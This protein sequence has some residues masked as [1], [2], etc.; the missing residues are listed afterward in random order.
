MP[1]ADVLPDLDEHRTYL[2][3]RHRLA[4]YTTALNEVVRP[5]S[6]VV[7]LAS[8]TGIL[9]MLA[10]RAGAARVYAIE[11]AEIAGVARQVANA[12][13]FGELITIVRDH[14]RLV[15]LPEQAD[16]V[17]CDQVGGFGVDAGILDVA[18][19]AREKFLKP[20]GVLVPR[21]VDLFLAPVEYPRGRDRRLFWRSRPA[22]LDFNAAAEIADN[23]LDRVRFD[24]ENLLAA[25]AR[26]AQ[27]DLM[28]PCSL[29]LRV[30]IET[31]V[32]REGILDGLGGWFEA[33]LSNSAVMT[34]APAAAHRVRRRQVFFPIAGPAGQVRVSPGTM[35][36]ASVQMLADD[37]FAWQVSVVPERG[38]PLTFLQTTVRGML[39]T[40]DDLRRGDPN[41]RPIRNEGCAALLTV[42]SM[43]DGRRSLADIEEE[44]FRLHSD[45]FSSRQEATAFVASV[46]ARNTRQ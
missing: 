4:A 36:E 26:G 3:D 25:P 21:R 32:S 6:V 11:Q 45:L 39:L 29:P 1:L 37:V 2:R 27:M 15:R 14:S 31:R 18:R 13:G 16:V 17:V 9:G 46:I 35:V 34:N 19:E 7:D 5:G 24:V 8:G 20:G 33:H 22:G 28:N 41:S 44:V 10:C 30:S 42:M 12:N 38:E 43:C 23:S 40:K